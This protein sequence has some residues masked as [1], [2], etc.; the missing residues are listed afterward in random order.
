MHGH[1]SYIVGHSHLLYSLNW[2]GI[3]FK[4]LTV[5]LFLHSTMCVLY[6]PRAQGPR[7]TDTITECVLTLLNLLYTCLLTAIGAICKFL[8]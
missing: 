5:N 8:V 2:T 4:F 1:S 6:M 3:S 7:H